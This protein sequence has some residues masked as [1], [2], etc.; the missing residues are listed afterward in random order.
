MRNHTFGLLVIGTLVG[1]A[2]PAPFS[3]RK[4][5]EEYA[6]MVRGNGRRNAPA[7]RGVAA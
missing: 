5:A 7:T 4:P 3:F 2:S 6:A 1:C